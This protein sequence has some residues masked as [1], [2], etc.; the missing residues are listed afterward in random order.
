MSGAT[1]GGT[2][3]LG[4]LVKTLKVP[5]TDMLVCPV[6]Q[7]PVTVVVTV[8]VELDSSQLPTSQLPT[9]EMSGRTVGAEF[10]HDCAPKTVRYR[11]GKDAVRM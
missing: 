4:G 6:C 2:R 8:E 1:L 9:V 5:A 7:A 3:P 10:R 11:T